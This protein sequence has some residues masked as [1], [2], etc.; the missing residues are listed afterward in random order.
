MQE[1]H[2][3]DASDFDYLDSLGY[4][5]IISE[6]QQDLYTIHANNQFSTLNSSLDCRTDSDIDPMQPLC[7]SMD[8]NANINR[9]VCGQPRANRLNVLK[10][11]YVKFERKIPTLVADFCTYYAPH[12]NKTVIYYYDATALDSNYAMNDQGLPLG[13]CPRV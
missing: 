4:D 5:K 2:K 9:I 12:P 13:G 1:Y 3:Y 6:A 10:S 8:Y 7:I 11:F